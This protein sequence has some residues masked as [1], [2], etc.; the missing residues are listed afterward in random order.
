MKETN[1]KIRLVIGAVALLLAGVLVSYFLLRYQKDWIMLVGIIV[2]G[3]IFLK[4]FRYEN[5][6]KYIYDK[7]S[8][9]LNVLAII[10]IVIALTLLPDSA[11]TMM[12]EKYQGIVYFLSFLCWFIGLY[13]LSIKSEYKNRIEN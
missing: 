6:E 2:F 13:F 4:C 3:I 8:K 7:L 11:V 1:C 12:N 9:Y 5:F 10:L